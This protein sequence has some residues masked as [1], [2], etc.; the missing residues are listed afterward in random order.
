MLHAAAG[1]CFISG[2][3][4]QM[5]EEQERTTMSLRHVSVNKPRG[6]VVERGPGCFTPHRV[7]I[8]IGLGQSDNLICY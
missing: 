3:Y 4:L 2:L 6:T 8:R 7:V 5:A 1:I